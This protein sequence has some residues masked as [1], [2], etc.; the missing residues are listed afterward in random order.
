MKSQAHVKNFD[1]HVNRHWASVWTFE[2]HHG[3]LE[4][5]HRDIVDDAT[6]HDVELVLDL[7]VDVLREPGDHVSW[8]I[9]STHAY[10]H[11]IMC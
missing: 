1:S 10:L 9:N 3:H 6:C 2:D 7:S 5:G 4:V 8:R 11:C